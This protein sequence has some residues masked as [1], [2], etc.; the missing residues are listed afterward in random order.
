MSSRQFQAIKMIAMDVDGVLTD[1]SMVYSDTAETKVFNAKDGLGIR[2]ART[3]GLE[4]VW[5]T[6]NTSPAVAKRAKDLRISALYQG[7]RLKT[8]ALADAAARFGLTR[9]EI[10]YMGDDLNDIPAFREVGLAIAPRDA[11][12]DVISTVHFVAE[13]NGGRGAVREIIEMILKAQGRWDE[14]VKAFVAELER[15]QIEGQIAEAVS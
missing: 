15:E 9:D 13:H 8:V 12:S 14:A 3:S 7:A 11:V 4:I 2:L 10:A 1:G 6:G 5:I